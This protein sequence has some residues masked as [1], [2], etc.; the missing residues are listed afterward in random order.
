MNS[1]PQQAPMRTA[2]VE[3]T[4]KGRQ[5]KMQFDVADAVVPP[6][7][8]LP[9]FRAVAESIMDIAVRDLAQAGTRI[10]CKMGCGACCRQLV[11]ISAMEAREIGRV[12]ARMPEPRRSEIRRR[13]A[14][15][16]KKFE[17][18]GLLEVLR[19]PTSVG[20][21][22]ERTL[23]TE[24]FALRVP[25]PFLENE[26]CSIY[27]DRPISC[28]EFL[29]VSNPEHCAEPTPEN[30]RAIMPLAGPIGSKVP[31]I[32][33][34]PNGKP[35]EWVPLILAL[36]YSAKHREEPPRRHAMQVV[37]DFFNRFEA[38]GDKGKQEPA[39]RLPK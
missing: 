9:L 32:D 4:V 17:E 38:P 36:E 27:A 19:D 35:V 18:A 28:R 31:K 10:S 24:Y 30:V 39:G 13:F 6:G 16:L 33:L 26:S 14:E 29:V 11:P 1:Q 8:L 20:K 21:E 15:A 3:L 22:R 25:C 7:D 23:G 37:A 12:V 2:Q 34:L 5:L